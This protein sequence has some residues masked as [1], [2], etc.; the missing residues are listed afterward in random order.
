MGKYDWAE[1]WDIMEKDLTE[2][3][4]LLGAA[5]Q[6]RERLE[7]ELQEAK[8]RGVSVPTVIG[9]DWLWRHSASTSA[10]VHRSGARRLVLVR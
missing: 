3:V 4:D 7:A 1:R 8:S 9:C 10:A 6:E 5:A 2:A